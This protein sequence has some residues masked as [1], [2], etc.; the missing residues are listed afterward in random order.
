MNKEGFQSPHVIDSP[1][2]GGKDKYRL[3]MVYKFITDNTPSNVK[4]I[5]G[6]ERLPGDFDI[7]KYHVIKVSKSYSLLLEEEN[8]EVSNLISRLI[9]K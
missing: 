2:T 7:K 6:V 9:S 4:L 3:P 5:L 1:N 8:Q